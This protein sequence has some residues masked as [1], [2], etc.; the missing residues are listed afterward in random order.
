[1]SQKEHK[2]CFQMSPKPH[3][4]SF[5]VR[6]YLRLKTNKKKKNKSLKLVEFLNFSK[7]TAYSKG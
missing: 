7:I 4:E 6:L 5:L 1:M 2:K 3:S